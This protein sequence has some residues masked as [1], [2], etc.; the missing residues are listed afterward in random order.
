MRKSL[1]LSALF[2]LSFSALR[3][4]GLPRFR[5]LPDASQG[6]VASS[7]SSPSKS[8]GAAEG[9][10]IKLCDALNSWTYIVKENKTDYMCYIHIPAEMAT[11]IAGNRITEIMFSV[12]S[13]Y[14]T[15]RTGSVFVAEDISAGPVSSTACEVVDSYAEYQ[16]G[17]APYQTVVLEEPYTVRENTGFYFGYRVN[18]CRYST[19][20]GADYPVAVD[21]RTPNGFSGTVMTAS[22]KAGTGLWEMATDVGTN[23]FLVARTV[24]EAKGFRNVFTLGNLSLGDFTLP[25]V[26]ADRLSA[27][28]VSA[29]NVGGD[30]VT[31]IEYALVINGVQG[32]VRTLDVDIA[33]YS[34][35]SLSIPTEGLVNGRNNITVHVFSVNGEPQGV[36]ASASCIV[37]DGVGFT[38]RIVVEE[39]TGTWC[40]YCPRGIVALEKMRE[41]YPDTFIG[42]EV[43]KG[44]AMQSATYAPLLNFF[45]SYPHCII[46]RDPLYTFDPS[47]ATLDMCCG[48]DYWGGQL[49]PAD[50]ALSVEEG[51][52]V[53]DVTATTTF[54]YD[55]V[56]ADYRLAFALLEDGLVAVQSNYYSGQTGMLEWWE[57][58]DSKVQ[59]TYGHTAVD[60]F[61]CWGVAG[62]IP[63][64]IVAGSP[65]TYSCALSTKRVKDTTRASV[66]AMLIDTR[67]GTILNA[68]QAAP[69][70]SSAV[71]AAAA[72]H[73]AQTFYNL[74]GMRLSSPS[75]PSLVI[76]RDA[77]AARK[78]VIR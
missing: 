3:A 28:D 66:V 55:E 43:H 60:I 51:D 47:T 7:V 57:E 37:V 52:G 75:R 72:A 56:D 74:Q 29:R 67:T 14:A 2:A 46:N 61:D 25:V 10:T 65:M 17:N 39:G 35:A 21:G 70:P 48:A 31:S 76:S 40:G 20:A 30:R 58:Q 1:L 62:S 54:A 8:D 6:A 44:D 9:F 53:F 41:K 49:A 42:I 68:A 13:D 19:V 27:L 77:S 71:T 33:P 34:N 26:T 50:I 15:T 59:W 38:R 22:S 78:V 45:P 63:S 24:G 11:T 16:K 32:E 64:T 73:G 36:S 12:A 5:H 23:L 69:A 4:E 18:Q